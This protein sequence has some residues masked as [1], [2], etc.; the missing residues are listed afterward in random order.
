MQL[1]RVTFRNNCSAACICHIDRKCT[2]KTYVPLRGMDRHTHSH[3][4]VPKLAVL[5]A[6][7]DE[8]TKRNRLLLVIVLAEF[9]DH[10][11]RNW[12]LDIPDSYFEMVVNPMFP[13]FCSLKDECIVTRKTPQRF[14]YRVNTVACWNCWFP[15][16]SSI[17]CSQYC[18]RITKQKLRLA[19]RNDSHFC[20]THTAR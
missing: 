8:S 18:G 1:C 10:K 5:T 14:K 16:D 2:I 3:T 7:T 17:S 4:M 9:I 15:P 13:S 20:V 6:T 12:F 11:L 19:L